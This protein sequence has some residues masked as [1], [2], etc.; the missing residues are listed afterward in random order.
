MEHLL[1]AIRFVKLGQNADEVGEQG[2]RDN[3]QSR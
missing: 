1:E 3:M 2:G